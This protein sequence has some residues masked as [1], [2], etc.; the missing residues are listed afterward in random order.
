MIGN[1]KPIL[2]NE[3][4]W[5]CIETSVISVNVLIESLQ[6]WWED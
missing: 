1:N 6:G 4:M 5:V 2:F 3:L